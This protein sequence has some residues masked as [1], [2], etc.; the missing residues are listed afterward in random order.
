[1][2]CVNLNILYI[3]CYI[4][5]AAIAV[6]VIVAIGFCCPMLRPCNFHH[7]VIITTLHTDECQCIVYV[8]S[9]HSQTTA[10]VTT[11]SRTVGQLHGRLPYQI[12]RK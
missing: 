7:G 1:M 8:E 9:P 4:A 5:V 2:E 10:A 3:T 11:H 12:V 6:S